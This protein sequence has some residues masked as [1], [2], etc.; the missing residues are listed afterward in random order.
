VVFIEIFPPLA[1]GWV[2]KRPIVFVLIRSMLA[3]KFGILWVSE[4]TPQS[5]DHRQVPH[6]QAGIFFC[7]Q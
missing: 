4:Q 6:H 1:I 2:P 3:H 7:A 5:I